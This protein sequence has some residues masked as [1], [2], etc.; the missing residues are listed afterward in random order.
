MLGIIGGNFGTHLKNILDIP[1]LVYDLKFSND[2][3]GFMNQVDKVIVAVENKNHYGVIKKYLLAGKDVLCLKPFV[4][5]TNEAKDLFNISKEK[6]KILKIGFNQRYK[7][8]IKEKNLVEKA[9]L[10]WVSK[11]DRILFDEFYNVKYDIGV[12]LLDIIFQKFGLI[13]PE[14]KNRVLY[15]YTAKI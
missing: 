9:D 14:K 7:I 12:H 10:L 11:K 15:K 13:Y 5:S 8:G 6:N 2:E 4:L 1:V 3:Q